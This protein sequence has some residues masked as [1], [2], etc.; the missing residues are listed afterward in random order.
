MP[1]GG[2]IVFDKRECGYDTRADGPSWRPGVLTFHCCQWAKRGK[3]SDRW[4]AEGGLTAAAGRSG[5]GEGQKGELEGRGQ[6]MK[7]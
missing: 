1:V 3:N 2:S 4:K 6:E 5:R 7:R